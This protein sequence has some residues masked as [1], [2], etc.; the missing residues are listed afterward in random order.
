MADYYRNA[1]LTIAAS[2]ASNSNEGFLGQLERARIKKMHCASHDKQFTCIVTD[3]SSNASSCEDQNPLYTRGWVFQEMLLSPRVLS[4]G[5]KELEWY[6]QR[7]NWCECSYLFPDGGMELHHHSRHWKYIRREPFFSSLQDW[8]KIVREFTKR[9]LTF[10]SDKLPA[11][12]GLA[13]RWNEKCV[14][15]SRLPYLAGIWKANPFM[16]ESLLWRAGEGKGVDLEKP[17]PPSWSWASV[18]SWIFYDVAL[19]G[20]YGV[21]LLSAETQLRGSNAYG[22]VTG[23]FL[24]VKGSL[25]KVQL[26]IISSTEPLYNFTVL[27]QLTGES[28]PVE[29]EELIRDKGAVRLSEALKHLRFFPDTELVLGPVEPSRLESERTYRRSTT[30][31]ESGSKTDS[32]SGVVYCLRFL[33]RPVPPLTRPIYLLVLRCVDEDTQTYERIGLL[34]LEMVEQNRQFFREMEAQELTMA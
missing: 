19:E 26:D 29:I 18:G 9:D 7:Q 15:A 4:F 17:G 10:S 22:E 2:R 30:P 31:R 6:C 24:R 11:L 3:P 12:S 13:T 21:S 5:A 34:S 23:G 32:E 20:Y 25:L 33:T 1:Y 16:W 27:P 8:M 28:T 14:I